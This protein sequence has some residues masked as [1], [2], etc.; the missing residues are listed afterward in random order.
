M[1]GRGSPSSCAPQA[2]VLVYDAGPAFPTGRDAGDLAVLPYLRHRGVR[3]VDALVIS[4]GDLDHRGGVDS[5][6]AGMPVARVLAGPS[7]GPLS[8]PRSPCWR[9]QRWT[10]DGVEFELL[11]PAHSARA[12]DNDSSCV[13]LIRSGAGS[14]LLAGDVEAV[15]ESEIVASGL[16]RT[17][18]G[19]RASSRQP[20][21]F[22]CAVRRATSRPELALVSAG[23]R[24]RWGLPRPEV[25]ERWRD[26]GA[27]VAH[28]C[29]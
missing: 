23:Y 27:R 28:D 5:V 24:N 11:H 20:H 7:V 15:A 17:A 21:V 14:V 26:A 1:W 3:H 8:R 9:G 10:W 12:S 29:G 13:L 22:H 19:R 16:P 18:V 4:H 2:H 25:V 6:L